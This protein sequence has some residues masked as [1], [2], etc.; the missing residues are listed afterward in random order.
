M[1]AR[2]GHCD[3]PPAGVKGQTAAP[4][5]KD[6]HLWPQLEGNRAEPR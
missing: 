3:T 4:P 5:I 1:R 2:R 6:D